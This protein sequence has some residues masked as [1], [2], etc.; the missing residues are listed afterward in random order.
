M[1]VQNVSTGGTT[2]VSFTVAKGDLPE[3]LRA[4]ESA[5]KE[6]GASAVSHDAEVAKISVVGIG[7][8]T[9]T[10]VATAMFDALAAA[11]INIQMITTSEIKIS[12]LVDRASAVAALR[13]V[14]K[15][16]LLDRAQWRRIAV[17]HPSLSGSRIMKLAPLADNGRRRRRGPSARHGRPRHRRG[18]A[19]RVAG[20][21]RPVPRTRPARLRRRVFRAIAEAGVFVDMIVQN[22]GHRR[23]SA[24]VVHR[25]ARRGR[26]VPSKPCGPPVVHGEVSVEPA[27]AKLSVIGVGMRTH[28]GVATRMFAALADRGI[29]INLINTSEVRINVATDVARGQEGLECLK[30]AF[31]L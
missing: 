15:A 23:G 26:A 2:E 9:H 16:F 7:M 30:R 24:A 17:P 1:I 6:I 21:D 29:N 12:V 27:M 5:A 20:P 8:R 31:A 11:G 3:T 22:V 10:G 25:A 13:A 18:R 4:A 28:T 19:G 14:H